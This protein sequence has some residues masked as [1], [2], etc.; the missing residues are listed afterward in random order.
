MLKS[1]LALIA[2]L[3]LDTNATVSDKVIAGSIANGCFDQG[4]IVVSSGPLDIAIAGAGWI[5]LLAKDGTIVYTRDGALGM[6]Q[7]GR[8][9][10]RPSGLPVVIRGDNDEFT[11]VSL[12][13]SATRPFD[14][15]RTGRSARLNS[16]SFSDE[17]ALVGY[18]NDGQSSE[19][20]QLKLAAFENSHGLVAQDTKAGLHRASARVGEIAYGAPTTNPFGKIVARHLEIDPKR[21]H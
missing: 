16:M 8:L 6:D 19:L 12:T 11:T 15:G 18:Y 3:S 7:Q 2:I 17:G 5:P 1:L 21:G 10:H 4:R 14:Q 9:S 20:A 13:A